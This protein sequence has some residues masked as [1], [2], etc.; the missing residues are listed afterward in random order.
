[1]TPARH[2]TDGRSIE[3]EKAEGYSATPRRISGQRI[4]G[5]A[6]IVSLRMRRVYRKGPQL[7][8]GDIFCNLIV[9][10]QLRRRFK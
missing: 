8:K 4:R 10:F 7:R 3:M 5:R 9:E 6:V 1:M 2:E